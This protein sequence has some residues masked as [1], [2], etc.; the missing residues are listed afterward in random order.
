MP[1]NEDDLASFKSSFYIKILP[2]SSL[3]VFIINLKIIVDNYLEK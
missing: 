2:V 3:A 1:C